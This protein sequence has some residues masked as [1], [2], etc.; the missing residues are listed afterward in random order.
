MAFYDGGVFT[1]IDVP[2]A[3][4][5]GLRDQLAARSWGMFPMARGAHSFLKDGAF[6]TIDVPGATFTCA[7][8]INIAARS[9][10]SSSTAWG[11]T[12]FYYGGGTF[13]TIDVP[14]A[15]S[16]E[17]FGINNRVPDRGAVQRGLSDRRR[18]HV[19]PCR[20]TR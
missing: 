20:G 15:A 11:P 5:R 3:F 9:W 16:N 14:G 10:G 18:R 2:G 12:V 13:T 1:T 19:H 4:H 17:A 7:I 8:G 6:T